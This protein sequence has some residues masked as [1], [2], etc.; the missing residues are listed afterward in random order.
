MVWGEVTCGVVLLPLVGDDFHYADHDP[1]NC[2]PI[3]HALRS[4]AHRKARRR[5]G[6]SFTAGHDPI[7][8]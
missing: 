1:Y 7:I 6:R 3:Y 8:V 2:K 5:A 4:A